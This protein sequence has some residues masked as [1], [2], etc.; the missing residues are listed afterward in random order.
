[1][2]FIWIRGLPR[3]YWNILVVGWSGRVFLSEEIKE[4]CCVCSNVRFPSVFFVELC[5]KLSNLAPAGSTLR[6]YSI[7]KLLFS[8]AAWRSVGISYWWLLRRSLEGVLN[9][10]CSEL[11]C[12]SCS[13]RRDWG[14]KFCESF[15]VKTNYRVAFES[16]LDF[17]FFPLNCKKSLFSVDGVVLVVSV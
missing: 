5:L 1:M 4:D 15:Y 8:L 16:C 3:Y 14:A 10:S 13:Q 9:S 2:Y 11:L 17:S 12:N 6:F 7:F